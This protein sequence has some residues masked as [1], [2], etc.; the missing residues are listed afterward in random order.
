MVTQENNLWI[1]INHWLLVLKL[2]NINTEFIRMKHKKALWKMVPSCKLCSHRRCFPSGPN[3]FF[4]LNKFIFWLSV[5]ISGP[6]ILGPFWAMYQT[7]DEYSYYQEV[8]FPIFSL[9]RECFFLAKVP[10]FAVRKT[11]LTVATKFVYMYFSCLFLCLT[12]AKI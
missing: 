6:I 1:F 8:P 9:P 7:F 10:F 12:R 4:S 2:G 5:I 11:R 3:M